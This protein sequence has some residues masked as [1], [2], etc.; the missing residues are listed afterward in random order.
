MA[1][2]LEFWPLGL[3]FLEVAVDSGFAVALL[4]RF[5]GADLH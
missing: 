4:R 3:E 5:A 1:W 2:P